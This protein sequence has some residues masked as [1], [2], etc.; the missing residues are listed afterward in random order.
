MS[1][2][3]KPPGIDPS[4][5]QAFAARSKVHNTQPASR[6]T[7]SAS[8]DAQRCLFGGNSDRQRDCLEHVPG[9]PIHPEHRRFAD[10]PD[11]AAV[12][13]DVWDQDLTQRKRRDELVGLG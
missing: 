12:T 11:T 3:L 2:V 6:W 9:R 13:Y 1:F 8:R 10:C 7:V 5:T 4:T